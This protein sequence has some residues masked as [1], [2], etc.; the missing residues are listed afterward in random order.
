M[1]TPKLATPVAPDRIRCPVC[2]DRS[3]RAMC[4]ECEGRG[5][6]TRGDWTAWHARSQGRTR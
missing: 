2:G 3:K 4:P 1:E 6:L 5:W